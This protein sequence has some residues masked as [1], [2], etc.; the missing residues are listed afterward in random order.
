MASDFS[1]AGHEF[2]GVWYLKNHGFWGPAS[3][4][5]R[6]VSFREGDRVPWTPKTM[7]NEGFNPQNMGYSP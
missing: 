3:W 4:Q 5:V 6:T 1:P 2:S 7:K